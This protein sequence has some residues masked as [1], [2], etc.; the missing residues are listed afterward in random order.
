MGAGHTVTALYEIIP[1]DSDGEAPSVE[2]LKYQTSQSISGKA[3]IIIPDACKYSNVPS[4][5]IRSG[6]LWPAFTKTS[7]AVF[8]SYSA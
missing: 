5:L 4:V 2:P 8:K 6:G 7:S 3:P 1:N